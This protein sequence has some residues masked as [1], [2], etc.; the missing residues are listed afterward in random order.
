MTKHFGLALI[1]SVPLFVSHID[2]IA[3]TV[4]TT[5]DTTKSVAESAFVKGVSLVG[6]AKGIL[7]DIIY[8]FYNISSPAKQYLVIW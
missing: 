6:T 7:Y 4:S 5:V 3:S 8:I 1:I 2:K